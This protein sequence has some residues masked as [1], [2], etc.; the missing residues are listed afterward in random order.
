M[1]L[2]LVHQ[3]RSP[4]AVTGITRVENERAGINLA[5]RIELSRDLRVA[6]HDARCQGHMFQRRQHIQ[7]MCGCYVKRKVL[8]ISIGLCRATLPRFL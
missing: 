7:A 6:S 4:G 3:F 5:V 1:S 8:Y 2:A